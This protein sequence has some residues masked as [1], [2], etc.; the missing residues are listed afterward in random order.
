MVSPS[1]IQAPFLQ[2][3][4]SI[5]NRF[6]SKVCPIAN[7]FRL[8]QNQQLFDRSIK[9]AAQ[10]A[11]F[12]MLSAYVLILLLR[13]SEMRISD[14]VGLSVD[15]LSERRL[16][17]H[18]QKT[19]VAVHTVLP[20]FC[21]FELH[22]LATSRLKALLLVGH[23]ALD[24]AVRRWQTQLRRLFEL[25]SFPMVTNRFRDIFPVELPLAGV[26][27]ERVS[28]L[29]GRQSIA[30]TERRYNPWVHSRQQQLRLIRRELG[31]SL[32]CDIAEDTR[33]S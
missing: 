9:S 19:G 4:T 8:R 27:I 25:A 20:H 6:S 16:F 21:V 31:N 12:K 14:P 10:T 30:I 11:D 2:G 17:L 28:V 15:R 22:L 23:G 13:Y 24:S 32:C 3:P 18:I 7:T 29:L 26:P 1:S 5:L 33:R